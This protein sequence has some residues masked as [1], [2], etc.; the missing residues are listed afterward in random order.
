LT[1]TLAQGAALVRGEITLAEGQTLPAKLSV[2][3]VPAETAQAEEPLR[4]FASP[5]STAGGFYLS[6]VAPG[7]YWILAQPG[8]DDT[9]TEMSKLRLP[10][11][12]KTRSLLRHAAE[13]RKTEIELKPCHD[14]TFRLPFQ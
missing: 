11:A 13:Q 12:A 4:Y 8:T 6:N 3:L 1:I 14:V 2:Y 10:D 9:R 5:V 7:R